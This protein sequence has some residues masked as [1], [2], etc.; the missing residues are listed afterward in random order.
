M[1]FIK[2]AK[3]YEKF[4]KGEKLTRKQAMLAQ[5]FMCNGFEESA[6]DCQ[7][8]K[9]CPLYEYHPHKNKRG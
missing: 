5:C 9:T 7:N 3:E 2:G 4:E 8:S 1:G 6:I